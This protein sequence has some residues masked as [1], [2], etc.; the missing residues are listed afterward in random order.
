MRQCRRSRDK[1]FSD[2]KTVVK[3][4]LASYCAALETYFF[5]QG[6][7][8]STGADVCSVGDFRF[9]SWTTDIF[10]SVTMLSPVAFAALRGAWGDLHPHRRL[11]FPRTA[12][13]SLSSHVRGRYADRFGGTTLCRRELLVVAISW[14]AAPTQTSRPLYF[15]ASFQMRM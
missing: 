5:F 1:R 4:P 8:V 2:R 10:P 12:D 14:V 15:V 6:R 9:A 7:V 13:R 3:P 11:R